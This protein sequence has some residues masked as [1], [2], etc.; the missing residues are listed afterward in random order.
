MYKRS[1]AAAFI[2][3]LF[4]VGCVIRTEH[5]IDAHITLDI[6]HIREQAEEVLDFIEGK[7]DTLPGLEEPTADSGQSRQWYALAL[8]ALNPMQVAHADTLKTSSPRVTEIAKSLRERNAD[9]SKLKSQGCL[10]E[11]NRG[12][13]E[14]RDCEAIADAD[15]KNA[16]QQLL[17]D[18]NRDRKALYNEITRLNA[19]EGATVSSIEGVY[20][21]ERASRAG[22]GEW[23]Q[24]PAGGELLTEFKQT[25]VGKKLGDKA[26][27]NAWVQVP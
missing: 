7:S 18:E 5:T 11:S 24:V 3:T 12:Y 19:A 15:A 26:T 13:V 25:A 21:L 20:A 4:V 14:L 2:A 23:I 9:I 8:N 1:F 10:G 22:A 27:A 16:A 6:R 17:A